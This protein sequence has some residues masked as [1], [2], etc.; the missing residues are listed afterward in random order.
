MDFSARRLTGNEVLKNAI[1]LAIVLAFIW[2]MERQRGIATFPIHRADILLL[3]PLSI[4]IFFKQSE[5]PFW[6]FWGIALGCFLMHFM[7][8]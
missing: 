3:A 5:K 7:G 8:E 6:F 2:I 4:A 1:R